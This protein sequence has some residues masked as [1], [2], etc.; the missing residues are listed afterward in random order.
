MDW[1]YLRNFWEGFVVIFL[2]FACWCAS[3]HVAEETSEAATL[4]IRPSSAFIGAQWWVHVTYRPFYPSTM[5]VSLSRLFYRVCSN[6]WR[7]KSILWIGLFYYCF[8][9]VYLIL[10][11]SWCWKSEAYHFVSKHIAQ[12]LLKFTL[13][14]FSDEFRTFYIFSKHSI[15]C[16]VQTKL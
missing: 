9:F 13:F 3:Q 2:F 11:S 14:Q 7:L 8:C 5:N 6:I 16:I 12:A 4:P 10:P 1:L 15:I